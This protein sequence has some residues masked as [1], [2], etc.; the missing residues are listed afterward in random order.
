MIDLTPALRL[1]AANRRRVLARQDPVDAQ[2]R[3]LDK[4]V[5]T[6][7]QT[8]FGWDHRFHRLSSVADFQATV[9]LRR[10]DDMWRD[11][12]KPTFPRLDNVTWPGMVPYFAVTSGTTSGSSKYIP[13]T[14]AMNRSNTF[15]GLDL[16][17]HHVTHRPRS[18]VFGGKSFMLGGSTDLVAEAPGIW[19]GDLSGIAI[20]RLPWWAKQ[21]AFPPLEIALLTDWEDKLKRLADLSPSADIRVL[22]GT[23]SW[24]LILFD[25]LSAG[26]GRTVT[27]RDVYP[28][29][30]LLIHG[31]VNFKPYRARFEA[32]LAGGAELREVYPASEGFIALQDETPEDGLRL[33]LD[34]GLF[35]EFVPVEELDAPNPRRFWIKTVETGVNYALVLSTCSGCWS[36]V[37]GDTVR[38]VSVKPP[39]ILITG[40]TSYSMSA[41]GE[42]LIGEEVE[43]AVAA[44]AQAIGAAVTDF[45][46]GAVFPQGPGELGGHLYVVEFDTRPNEAALVT[47]ARVIDETLSRRNDDYRAH[48][49]DGFGMKAPQVKAVAPGTF[50]AW[51]KARGRLGGQN[52]VPR[53]IN[54]TGLFQTLVAFG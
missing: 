45:S 6:A 25:K 16:L 15:A 19:S 22:T 24:L 41:F 1:Y 53:I 8:R 29:L 23:P 47:F 52:K 14:A 37:I 50:A 3:T 35:F 4:L 34:N 7:A 2:E 54:D 44:G 32:F 12:W 38:F 9:P 36:Y 18:R 42:H 21:F 43:D 27:A 33:L 10:Y 31:G 30:E 51:M 17:T 26:A 39:R 46:M 49:A 48:R 20:K 13:V 40:R 5:S 11:Y 28:K